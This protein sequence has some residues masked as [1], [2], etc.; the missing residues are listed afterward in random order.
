[1]KSSCIAS[2]V[3]AAAFAVGEAT[4]QS[5]WYIQ[6]RDSLGPELV[7]VRFT[8]ALTGWT[9]GGDNAILHTTNGGLTWYAQTS[10]VVGGGF[11]S[12]YFVDSLTGWAAGNAIVHTTDG[13]NTWETQVPPSNGPVGYSSISF[14]D[15]TRGWSVGGVSWVGHHFIRHTTDGGKSWSEQRSGSG[16]LRSVCFVDSSTGW[17]V[18]DGIILRTTNGGTTWETQASGSSADLV[19]VSFPIK[20][21]GWAVGR[22]DGTLSTILNT[23]NGGTTWN[24]QLCD[25]TRWLCSIYFIDAL[26]G[27]ATGYDSEDAAAILHTTDGGSTWSAQPTG[28]RRLTIRSIDFSD[29]TTGWAVGDGGTILHTTN[30]GVTFVEGG[31]RGGVPTEFSLWQNY[32][33]PFNPGTTINY[34]LPHS[35]IVRLSVCDLLGREVS[36]L[37]NERKDAGVHEVKFDGS[38]LASGVYF[39]RLSVSPLARQDLVTQERDGQAGDFTRTKR[40]LLLK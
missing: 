36:V 31:L 14:T 23:T 4:A 11:A 28:L 19:S 27:W 5:G 20:S 15:A 17:V 7:S 35:S 21:T 25:S 34:E 2:L 26:R 13:G 30:G 10:G 6:H 18:G 8:D 16:L 22:F 9:V 24:A 40:L 39:Y 33:N 1:M 29:S 38:N 3:V 37:V 32:P 12:V